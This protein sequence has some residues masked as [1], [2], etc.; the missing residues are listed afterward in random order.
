[1]KFYC[2]NVFKEDLM[3]LDLN[4]YRFLVYYVGLNFED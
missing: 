4:Y 3:N 1:M 2:D